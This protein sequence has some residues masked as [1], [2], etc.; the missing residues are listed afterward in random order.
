MEPPPRVWGPAFPNHARIC[1]D[2]VPLGPFAYIDLLLMWWLSQIRQ[3]RRQASETPLHLDASSNYLAPNISRMGES[4]DR[5]APWQMREASL[6]LGHRRLLGV[7]VVACPGGVWGASPQL[8]AED[9]DGRC[10]LVSRGGRRQDESDLL[11]P[12]AYMR[13][14]CE[15]RADETVRVEASGRVGHAPSRGH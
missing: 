6:C 4:V 13:V 8:R 15:R 14:R 2:L 1:P 9:H 10:C 11:F 7:Q 5:P 12:S 3:Y